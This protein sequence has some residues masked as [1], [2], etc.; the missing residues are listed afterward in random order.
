ML[1]RFE[2][3]WLRCALAAGPAPAAVEILGQAACVKPRPF[4]C[5]Q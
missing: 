4:L 3:F 2:Y 5:C 1:S